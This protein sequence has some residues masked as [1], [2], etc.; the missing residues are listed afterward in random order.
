VGR[1]CCR[2]LAVLFCEPIPSV[3][4]LVFLL[5]SAAIGDENYFKFNCLGYQ[6]IAGQGHHLGCFAASAGKSTST[7]SDEAA[8]AAG[9]SFSYAR[10]CRTNLRHSL[11]ALLISTRFLCPITKP[12]RRLSV[13]VQR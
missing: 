7:Y 2:E 10:K 13:G 3:I 8:V 6:A 5:V 11:T 4:L 12:L 1:A 9:H